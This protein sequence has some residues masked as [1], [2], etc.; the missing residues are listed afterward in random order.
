MFLG[1]Q[2]NVTRPFAQEN[3]ASK[4]Q[5]NILAHFE[6][7][8]NKLPKRIPSYSFDEFYSTVVSTFQD[9]MSNY[10]GAHTHTIQCQCGTE[11]YDFNADTGYDY[12]YLDDSNP[13]IKLRAISKHMEMGM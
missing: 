2:A 7:S 9:R 5:H 13:E 11:W 6:C 1:E 3:Q 8:G 10:G 12:L 4:E